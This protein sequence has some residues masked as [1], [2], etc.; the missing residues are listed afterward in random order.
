MTINIRRRTV[1]DIAP[2]GQIWVCAACGKTNKCRKGIYNGWD[3]SCTLHAVLCYMKKEKGQW[4]AVIE[5]SD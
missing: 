3:T 1:R 5:L 2:L 4:R